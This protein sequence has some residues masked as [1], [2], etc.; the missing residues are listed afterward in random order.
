MTLP[1]YESCLRNVTIFDSELIIAGPEVYL[2]KETRTLKLVEQVINLGNGIF[3]LDCNFVQLPI[4]DI[5]SERIIVRF[6]EQH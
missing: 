6:H 3:I 2:R 4:L 5:H 1:S